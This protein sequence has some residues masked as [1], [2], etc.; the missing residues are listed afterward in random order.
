[1]VRVVRNKLPKGWAY[2]LKAS[3]LDGAIAKA[4]VETPVTLFL[5]HG[6]FWATRPLFTANFFLIGALVKN[7]EEQFWV[8]CRSVAAVD[9][10]AARAFI[11]ADAIPAFATW[12]AE[13]EALPANSTRRKTSEI[14]RDWV[15]SSV[16]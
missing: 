16:R 6:S 14:V 12:A 5:R 11:E 8:G 9:S 1:M 4:G 2:P 10:I 7:E 3:A 13:L 15:A